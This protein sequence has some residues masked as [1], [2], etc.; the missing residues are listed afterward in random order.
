MKKSLVFLCLVCWFSLPLVAQKIPRF[1]KVSIS[2]SGCTAYM[3]SVPEAFSQSFSPDSSVVYQGEC[4]FDGFEF[5]V[6]AVK[7]H[8]P[9]GGSDKDKE[10]LLVSYMDYLKGE[11]KVKASAG[12]GRGHHLDSEPSAV[13]VIDYWKDQQGGEI[14]VKAWINGEL[15]GFLYLSGKTEYPNFNVQQLFLNGFRF[16]KK[17]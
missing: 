8:L 17:K 13:G 4:T 3:P 16:P 9:V 15:I 6:I 7:F 5:G 2:T 11:F 14:A 1:Q 10:D 12:Y